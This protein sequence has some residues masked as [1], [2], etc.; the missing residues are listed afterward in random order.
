MK[1]KEPHSEFTFQIETKHYFK[2]NYWKP[3]FEKG[4][5]IEFAYRTFVWTSEAKDKAAVH[6]VIVAI[7]P[8]STTTSPSPPPPTHRKQKS[9][10]P[11]RPS[12]TPGPSIRIA[13]WPTSTTRSPCPRNCVKPTSRTTGPSCRRMGSTWPP[14]LRRAAWRN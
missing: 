14:P 10:R 9:S 11:L 13:P 5:D 6:C 3:L 2:H 4:V 7:L 8:Q 1:N 12:W